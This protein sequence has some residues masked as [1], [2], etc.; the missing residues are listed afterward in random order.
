MEQKTV[1]RIS[2]F[3]EEPITV[4]EALKLLNNTSIKEVE[5]NSLND[6]LNDTNLKELETNTTL[7][8]SFSN[9]KLIQYDT[10]DKNSL[11]NQD[12]LEY[13]N[14]VEK[15]VDAL[16]KY[17]NESL[18]LIDRDL[19]SINGVENVSGR[20]LFLKKLE[21]LKNPKILLASGTLFTGASLSIIAMPLGFVLGAK[22]AMGGLGLVSYIGYYYIKNKNQK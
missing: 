15:E 9:P 8:Y 1:D 4:S 11:I 14:E 6:F 3:I 17:M 22:V 7:F 19:E 21:K 10:K 18:E 13:I 20:E 2:D 12:Y 16:D 5:V